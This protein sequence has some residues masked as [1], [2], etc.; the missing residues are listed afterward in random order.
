MSVGKKFDVV[1]VGAGLAG[2]VCAGQLARLGLCVLLVDRRASLRHAIRT[3]GIFV[4]R[5]L[6]D[7]DLPADCLGPPIRHV[8]LY[9]P[10]GRTLTLE[11]PR[12]E[13]RIGRMAPLYESYL[14]RCVRAGVEWAS[15]TGYELAQP[16]AEGAVVHLRCGANAYQV[17]T[18]FVVGADGA[19]SAVARDLHLDR[20]KEWI[21]G[22]EDVVQGVPLV[23]PPCLHCFLDPVLAPGY[24]AWFANDGEEAH[25]GVAGYPQRFQALPALGAFRSRLARMVDLRREVRVE[26]RGGKIPVG[27][28]LRRIANPCGLLIGDAAGAVSPLTAGGLDPCFRLSC[29]AAGVIAD[30]LKTGNRT[31]IAR[32]AGHCFRRRFGGRLAL[33][34]LLS[35]VRWPWLVELGFLVSRPAFQHPLV[36]HIF[37]GRG[38]FPDAKPGR[39]VGVS[40]SST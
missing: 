31:V 2:L 16:A 11:A 13:F 36:R 30:Y 12:E 27:G 24:L 19:C 29:L 17:R 39:L 21:V 33:R 5:T 40:A 37:F 18:R 9:S 10:A 28:V 34:R 1:V 8:K 32:Y 23:G 3:T 7:F 15:G 20:N 4:R 35:A 6:E 26:R 25:I 38:S 22:V 14:E